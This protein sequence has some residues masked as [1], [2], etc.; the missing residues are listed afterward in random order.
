MSL[1]VWWTV[2]ALMAAGGLLWLVLSGFGDVPCQDGYWD[3]NQ[4]R[5]IPT[6]TGTTLP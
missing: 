1:K 3:A 4:H 5:C 2:I 6:G